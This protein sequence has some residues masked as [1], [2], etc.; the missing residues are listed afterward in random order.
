MNVPRT[1]P[2]AENEM[3]DIRQKIRPRIILL[4]VLTLLSVPAGGAS[5]TMAGYTWKNV[6]VGAG[7]FAPN[8]VF[9][10]AEKDLAYL[11]TD[12]GGAYRWHKPEQRWLP[13]QDGMAESNYFGIESIAADPR[14]AD[15][16]YI[17]AGMYR[18]EE[19]AIL[20]SR[21]R[22][23]SWETVPVPFRM[24]GNENG[25]GV[26]ERLAI[27]PGDTSILY[28]GSRHD[29][30]FRSTDKGTTWKKVES[31]PHAGHGL[32]ARGQPTNAGISFVIFDPASSKGGS[33]QTLY[34]GVADPVEQHLYRSR[35]G[36]RSWSPI[37]N[38]PPARLLPV[39]AELDGE[40]GFLYVAYCNGIGP[41]GVTDGALYKLDTDRDIWTDISPERGSARSSGGGYMAL[42]LD[43]QRPGTLIAATMNR[44]H[45]YDTL[46]RSTD[47]G[48]TWADIKPLSTHDVNASPFLLWGNKEADFGWWIAG[49][50]INPFDSNHVAYTTGATVYTTHD[51]SHKTRIQWR[52]WTEG[53]EQ[54]AIITL[55]SLPQGP[56]LLSGF[57]DLGGFAHERLDV[58]PSLQFI[59]PVFANT[60][61]IDYAGLSPNVV[62]RSGTPAHRSQD[63]APTLAYST[64]YG[65]SWQSISASGHED[66][67]G[68]TAIVVSAD[69]KRFV[70]T[71]PVAAWTEDRGKSWRTV[72]GLPA[73][74][75][76]V[77]DK[78][79]P[80]VFYAMDFATSRVFISSDGGASYRPLKTRGLPGNIREDQPTWREIPW[81][82]MA[83]PDGDLWFVSR[84]GLF[85][86]EDRG[87]SFRRI[88]SDV[89]VQVLSF[90]KPRAAGTKYTLFAIGV[91]DNSRAIWRSDD[92]GIHWSRLNDDKHQ[93]GRRFRVL[94]GDLQHHGR[95]YV[96][97]DGRGIVYG[98][99]VSKK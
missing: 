10:R 4:A 48:D 72:E 16:V 79:D 58:S 59:N 99:P 96:G 18:H 57:G 68:S 42:S 37:P 34:V 30:L 38:E 28:F 81:P 36:G 2:A 53:I 23:E 76:P 22:G 3:P 92:S 70:L 45:P 95:V 87:L 89:E 97:T 7:G 50:A 49:L 64:D 46:W 84:S 6:K 56:P 15:V 54:T 47:G 17:A 71:T 62:V 24:G 25:R 85:R 11:R 20:K 26:G 33:S 41:N 32:P 9:S 43:R 40:R 63:N 5:I 77:A 69:G 80:D 29:G 1:D 14:D 44:W 88:V 90:G 27:D 91:K 94:A 35:D 8:I 39:K 98:E 12:M 21:N 67:T 55:A 75:R 19:A 51:I 13:L 73:N 78:R 61:N 82:L 66:K 60:N 83:A 31:F 74:A 52:P 86:S 93:Y 65:R